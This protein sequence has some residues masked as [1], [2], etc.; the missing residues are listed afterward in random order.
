MA[1]SSLHVWLRSHRYHPS[2]GGCL[3]RGPSDPKKNI[4]KNMEVLEN[5]LI[6]RNLHRLFLRQIEGPAVVCLIFCVT[7]CHYLPIGRFWRET[8]GSSSTKNWK[9]GPKPIHHHLWDTSW[10]KCSEA[11]PRNNQS[12]TWLNRTSG[13]RWKLPLS[14]LITILITG[15]WLGHPSEKYESQLGWL[16]TQYMGK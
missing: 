11:V 8:F 12:T 14:I 9:Y 1:V 5:V 10:W 6:F 13:S 3:F 7:T 4:E 16:A 15:W 2:A